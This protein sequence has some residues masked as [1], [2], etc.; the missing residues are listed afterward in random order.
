MTTIRDIKK[1]IRSV[2][3]EE[4]HNLQQSEMYEQVDPFGSETPE[5]DLKDI[6]EQ[7]NEEEKPTDAQ[8]ALRSAVGDILANEYPEIWHRTGQAGHKLD[9]SYL[10]PEQEQVKKN[11]YERAFNSLPKNMQEEILGE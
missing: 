2:L 9:F 7:I 1:I 10:V 5:Y 6:D 4:K 8:W 3:V 11:V